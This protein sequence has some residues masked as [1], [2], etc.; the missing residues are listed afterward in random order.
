MN[1][2]KID[3]AEMSWNPVT[4]CRHGCPYCYAR[5]T[6][7]RFDA[8]LEDK[9]TVGGLHVLESKIKATL[10]P[11]GFEPTLHRYRLNQPERNKEGR[12][13]FVCSMAD[14]FRRWVPTEWIRD[15]LDACQRAPQ[16]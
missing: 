15:V 13:V 3:W 4:G 11:Y 2:T 16:H 7:R 9:E 10:Y 8:G 5:R 14:L 12:T 1:E 6:A